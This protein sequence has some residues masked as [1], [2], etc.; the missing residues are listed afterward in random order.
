MPKSNIIIKPTA[1]ISIG[2]TTATKIDIEDTTSATMAR[3]R[4]AFCS[5]P[6]SFSTY[7]VRLKDDKDCKATARFFNI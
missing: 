5:F 4:A 6:A 1:I 3:H 7:R 2:K